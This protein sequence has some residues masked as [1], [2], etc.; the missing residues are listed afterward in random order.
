MYVRGFAPDD[1]VSNGSAATVRC[2]PAGR[3]PLLPS[4]L[5]RLTGAG[6]THLSG[7]LHDLDFAGG[8]TTARG[9]RASARLWRRLMQIGA[10][11]SLRPALAGAGQEARSR[12]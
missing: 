12:S 4:T 1:L 11:W 8:Q 3:A 9:D 7:R 6:R 2:L 10:D 5:R